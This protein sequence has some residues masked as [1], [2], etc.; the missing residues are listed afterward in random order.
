MQLINK[1][2]IKMGQAEVKR[3]EWVKTI[4]RYAVAA[5]FNFLKWDKLKCVNIFCLNDN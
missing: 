3:N 5:N 4:S 2:E 1:F